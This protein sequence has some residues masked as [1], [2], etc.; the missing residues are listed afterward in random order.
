VTAVF[1]HVTIR[2]SERDVSERFFDTTLTPLGLDATYR[3]SAF[4][5]WDEFAITQA[6]GGHPATRRLH[7]AFT[8]PTREQVDAFW[9]AGVDA[10][11]EDD[12]PP[13]LR[14]HYADD[15]YAAFLRDPDGNSVEAVH[16]D[17]PRRR[18]GVVDHVRIRVAD[19]STARAF[20]RALAAA[21]GLR[22]RRDD[23]DGLALW[24][25][26][27]GGAFSLGPGL[28]TEN[29]HLAFP[30]DAGAVRRFYA[31]LTADGFQGNG[32]PGERP[33]YH[34]GYYAAYVLDPDGNNV[35]V[36]DHGRT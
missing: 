25:G 35:E 23:A 10:G 29:V 28:A 2:V 30:G 24:G 5:V 34:P 1:D 27:A 14:P 32:E 33:R 18:D 19:A 7:V 12:G 13:G 16:R 20:Y 11:Y 36:V 15:Y 4:A 9:H 26:P 17:R 22:V 8:A 6:D 31:E 21:T 3:S